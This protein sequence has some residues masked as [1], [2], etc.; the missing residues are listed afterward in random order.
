MT[1]INTTNCNSGVTTHF[2]KTSGHVVR[3]RPHELFKEQKEQIASDTTMAVTSG[4]FYVSTFDVVSDSDVQYFS[5]WAS[6]ERF[7]KEVE[8]FDKLYVALIQFSK[9]PCIVNKLICVKLVTVNG[10]TIN[11]TDIDKSKFM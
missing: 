9:Y 4:N 6:N 5:D 3:L 10:R 1:S 11:I 7:C 2:D 8:I